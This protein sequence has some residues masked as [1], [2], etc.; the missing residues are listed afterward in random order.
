MID[1]KDNF[2]G[3]DLNNADNLTSVGTIEVYAILQSAAVCAK[4]FECKLK[5]FTLSNVWTIFHLHDMKDL[6]F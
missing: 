5:Q 4:Y 1:I 6:D 2:G 3:D